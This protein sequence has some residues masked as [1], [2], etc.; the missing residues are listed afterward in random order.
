MNDYQDRAERL[1]VPTRPN[2][3]GPW[4]REGR[5]WERDVRRVAASIPDIEREAM[6]RLLGELEVG[7]ANNP[8]HH[9]AVIY[10]VREAIEQGQPL[11]GEAF[12]AAV[13]AS[14]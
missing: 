7:F 12:A 4:E 2:N 9:T 10:R 8:Q 3:G 14:R 6:L 11:P 13:K 5:Q 1:M